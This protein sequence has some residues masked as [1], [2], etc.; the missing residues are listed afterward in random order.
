[1]SQINKEWIEIHLREAL[2][3]LQEALRNIR[4]P[5]YS[6]IELE[7]DLAHT[8][9]H[10]NTAWN[11]RFESDESVARNQG[12]RFYEWRAFPRDIDMGASPT[13]A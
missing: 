2:D 9:N 3:Q 4:D 12:S 5:D 1:L 8:Y 13:S 7:I 6:D 10:I 11:S